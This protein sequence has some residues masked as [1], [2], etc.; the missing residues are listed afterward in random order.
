V[1]GQPRGPRP[2]GPVQ[3]EYGS[4][5][6][7][8]HAHVRRTRGVVRA[9]DGVVGR[10]PAARW[11]ALVG[12]WGGARHGG[13][14]GLSP[15]RLVGGEQLGD[16]RTVTLRLRWNSGGRQRPPGCFVAWGG[17]GKA[18]AG[19]ARGSNGGA[20]RAHREDE[21]AVVLL[22]DSGGEGAAFRRLTMDER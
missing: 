4:R 2:A 18:E 14:G 7:M 22:C 6:V 3:R 17:E 15:R 8:W 13:E 19:L 10:S 16:G 9:R 5:P 12:P 11:Q 20:G 1:V 21:S